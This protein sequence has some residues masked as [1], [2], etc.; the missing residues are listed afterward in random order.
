MDPTNIKELLFA[1][2]I[3]ILKYRYAI[4]VLFILVSSVVLAAG[5][6][7]PKTYTSRV[8]LHA[9]VT[10]IIGNLLEGKAEITKIDRA[11]EARDIIFTERIMRS[12]AVKANLPENENTVA[13]LRAKMKITANGDYVSILYSSS[14]R[15]EAFSVIDAVTQAF[16]METSRKKREE[17]QSA[18]E[19][20]DAQVSSYKRQLEEAEDAL[21]AFSAQNIDI[22]EDSVANRVTNYKNDI[23]ILTLEIEDSQSR[24]SSFEDE[25]AKESEFLKIETERQESFEERQLESFE[26]QLADLRLSYQDTHPDIVSLKD[27]IETL[28]VKVDSIVEK[29]EQNKQYTQVENTAY[30]QLKELINSERADLKAARN[31]LSNTKQLLEIALSNAETVASKQATYK[32]LTRDYSVTKEVY[33]DMLKRR[34]SARLS[35]T[36]DIEGQGVSY[37]IHEPASYPVHS[38]GLQ[39]KHFALIGPVLGFITPIGLLVAMVLMDPRVRSGSFMADNLSAHINVITTIPLYESAVSEFASK[40]SLIVLSALCIL[41]LVLYAA[42]SNGVGVLALIGISI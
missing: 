42:L 23:Q 27:Q 17:S 10:N 32:D 14:S 11:K 41:Y 2:K 8:V 31:R 16:L 15:D 19:F 34:E 24:L 37:K 33:E 20:I 36:L 30:T 22:T 3:E 5:F 1:L 39:L 4:V 9:D 7:M 38:D 13:K 40:R 25:L 35:M 6:F 18:Y 29:S 28:R 12:V 26:R 21:K